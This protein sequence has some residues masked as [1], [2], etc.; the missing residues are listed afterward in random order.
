MSLEQNKRLF[1]PDLKTCIERS[2]NYHYG[3]SAYETSDILAGFSK[4]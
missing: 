1:L 3:K 4:S 2:F